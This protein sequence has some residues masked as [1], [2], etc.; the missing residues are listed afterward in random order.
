MSSK[1]SRQPIFKSRQNMCLFQRLSPFGAMRPVSREWFS[2][3]DS[4][5]TRLVRFRKKKRGRP[6]GSRFVYCLVTAS[7]FRLLL[8]LPVFKSVSSVKIGVKP[9]A[10]IEEGRPVK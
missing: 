6:K 5:F 2:Q 1:P 10:A 4:S 8:L 7:V 3:S 9:F